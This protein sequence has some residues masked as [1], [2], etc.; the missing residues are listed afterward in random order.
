MSSKRIKTIPSERFD[1]CRGRLLRFVR[2]YGERRITVEA[3][4]WLGGVSAAELDEPHTA[5]AAAFDG[6]RLVGLA[7][8]ARHG[9]RAAFVVVHPAWRGAGI[10]PALL[11]E[12]IGRLGRLTCVVACDNTPSMAMCFRAGMT[13]VQLTTGGSGRPALRFVSADAQGRPAFPAA[14]GLEERRDD[15][16]TESTIEAGENALWHNR[17]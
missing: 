9:E 3:L 12:L 6:K 5:V 10:G 2:A 8:A 7:C 11:R 16:A 1:D 4:R 14:A 13:A 17:R 15:R